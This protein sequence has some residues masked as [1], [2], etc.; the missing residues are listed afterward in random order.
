MSL[1]LIAGALARPMLPRTEVPL[2]DAFWIRCL[3]AMAL[4][5]AWGS[6]PRNRIL[7]VH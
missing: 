6:E 1:Q 2:G 5:G 3:G 7:W 4:E